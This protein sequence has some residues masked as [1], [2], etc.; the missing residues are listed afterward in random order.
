MIPGKTL[1][2]PKILGKF[3]QTTHYS[4]GQNRRYSLEM[5]DASLSVNYELRTF[6]QVAQGC[7]VVICMW[8][9]MTIRLPDFL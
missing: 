5:Q 3:N 6:A 4:H 7:L 2:G 8:F 1:G 9:S